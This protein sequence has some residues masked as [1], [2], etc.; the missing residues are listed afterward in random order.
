MVKT[1][2]D[3]CKTYRNKHGEGYKEKDAARKRMEREKRKLLEPTKYREFKK[4]EATRIREYRI[5]KLR[6]QLA[7]SQQGLAPPSTPLPE[8]PSTSAFSCKQTLGRSI[9][10][11]EKSLPFSPR[12]K[13]EVVSSLAK[14]FKLRIAVQSNKPGRKKNML[15]DDERVW[16]ESVLE[17]ADITYTTPGRRD[18]IYVGMDGGKRRYKQKRYLLWKLRDLLEIINGSTSNENFLSFPET[19]EHK[20][21][22]RQLYDFLKV[23][24]E[25]FWNGKIPHSSCLCEICENTVLFAKGLNSALP[26]KEIPTTVHE[27]VELHSCDSDQESCMLGKCELCAK[28]DL[29]VKDFDSDKEVTFSQWNRVDNHIAKSIQ[30]LSFDQAIEKWNSALSVTKKH[31]HRKRKQVKAYND[32]K[33]NLKPR[34]VLIHVDYSESYSNAQ[35]DEIQSAYFGKQNFSIFTSCS[36]YRDHEEL[37]KVP[38]SVISESNDHSRIA[39]FSCVITIV[40]ELKRL[41][42]PIERVI[43]WS[44]GCASQFRSKFVFALLTHF[45]KGIN[46][47]WHYNEAHHGKGP[48]DG[49]GGT[50]KRV[51]YGLVK[52]RKVVINSAE[53]FAVEASKAVPSIKSIFLSQDDEIL[54]PSYVKNAPPIKGTLDIHCVKR[55]YN[56]ENVCFLEFFRLSDERE[57]F[58]I[59]Y[60]PRLNTLVCDHERN[61]EINDNVC[62]HC[63]EHYAEDGDTWLQCPSCR[64]WFHE[65]CFE[66]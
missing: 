42:G 21:S 28:S 43:L 57:P 65:F 31:I 41:V 13:I 25:I 60:Y 63:K 39:A 36:Y 37:K 1:N 29:S 59:Q 51:V 6:D 22:F 24:K 4:R 8:Q 32:H 40:N 62:G 53:E 18:A 55:G 3:Y 12:K 61:G 64:I 15:N 11:V 52:S 56:E 38:M 50:I 7:E 46:L 47:E 27:I 49:V 2:S 23:H 35:Q 16:L 19:F 54:E 10:R 34:E 45:E 30:S 33:V 44:D 14:K 66:K 26:P 17:R 48:M 5:K 58:F 20:L 9:R